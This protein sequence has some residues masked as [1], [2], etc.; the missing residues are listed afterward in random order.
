MTVYHNEF[1][2]I[3]IREINKEAWDI[4]KVTHKGTKWVKNYKL[5]MLTSE[6]E[7]MRMLEDESFDEFYAKINGI[8]NSKF[9]LGDKVGDA[10]IVRKILKS[11]PERFRLR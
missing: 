7:E 9:N 8:V 6:F 2:K 5:Q 10:W 4:F 3:F 11:L 1:K